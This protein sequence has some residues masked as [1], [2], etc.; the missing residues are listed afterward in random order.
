MGPQDSMAV[1]SKP[2]A[3]RAAPG[4][5]NSQRGLYMSRNFRCRQPS[6]QVLR[7]GGRLRP[8]GC[9]VVGTST[10]IRPASELR[11]T[12]SLANSMPGRPE[13]EIAHRSGPEGAQPAV[14][15]AHRKAEEQASQEAEHRVAQILV[16]E[17][18]GTRRDAA[19]EAV[20][21]DDVGAAAQL[22]YKETEVGEIVAVVGVAHHHIAA[23]GRFDAAEQRSPVAALGN[24]HDAS[25]ELRG[26]PR[27][28][29]GAAVVGDDDF[30]CNGIGLQ[31]G[32]R[33]PDAGGERSGLVQTG[34][35]DSELNTRFHLLRFRSAQ[36]EFDPG[37]HR[38]HRARTMLYPQGPSAAFPQCNA[39]S[40]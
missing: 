10:I 38:I 35:Q 7:C 34:Q 3:I 39:H 24:T 20:A 11:T 13:P 17:R 27:R 32:F 18:H 16:E 33:L 30:A 40:T 31:E 29:V 6:R 2:N 21:D 14:E 25:A 15:I 8:S 9:S 1:S 12:I 4:M 19:G 22:V 36:H 23:A 28:S 26:D 37:L 5:K